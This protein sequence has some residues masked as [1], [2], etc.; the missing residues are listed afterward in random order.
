MKKV[1]VVE[2]SEESEEDPKIGKAKEKSK[3]PAKFIKNGSSRHGVLRVK[4]SLC[5]QTMNYDLVALHSC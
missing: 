5:S 3:K 1:V 2:S 4:C